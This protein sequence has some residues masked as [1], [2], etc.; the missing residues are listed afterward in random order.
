[1]GGRP[2]SQCQRCARRSWAVSNVLAA[3]IFLKFWSKT[4]K[5]HLLQCRT[6][7][8]HMSDWDKNSESQV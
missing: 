2:K 5:N 8:G 1:M 7:R 3:G 4:H 6:R